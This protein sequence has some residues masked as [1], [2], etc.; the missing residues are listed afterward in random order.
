MDRKNGKCDH[1]V[2]WPEADPIAYG[3]QFCN[4]AG[5]GDGP[6]PVLPRSSA[7]P[8]KAVTR[9]ELDKCAGCGG[10]RTYAD[11]QCR[12]CNTPFP[13]ADGARAQLSANQKQPGT[14]PVCS[15]TV[16][17]ETKTGEWECSDCGEVY[18][19]PKARRG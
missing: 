18:S 17:Y 9:E 15:S 14:C 12:V 11:I 5:N 3:C 4:P 16:H 10:M 6:A 1:G 2:Y 19:A 7:D 8:L 13:Q